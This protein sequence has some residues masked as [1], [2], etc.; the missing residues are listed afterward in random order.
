MRSSRPILAHKAHKVL[1]KVLQAYLES[2]E[3]TKLLTKNEMQSSLPDDILNK[4]SILVAELDNSQLVI[5]VDSP[6]QHKVVS[7]VDTPNDE[8]NRKDAKK[9]RRREKDSTEKSEKKHKKDK[10]IENVNVPVDS[11]IA[12]MKKA[13]SD[14][15]KKGKK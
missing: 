5:P 11:T 15:L 13:L 4:L 14:K 2:T 8:I 3:Q 9:K 10:L 12:N 7:G 1:K 6:Q